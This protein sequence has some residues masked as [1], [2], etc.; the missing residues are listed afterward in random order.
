MFSIKAFYYSNCFSEIE[1]NETS[2][3]QN[4]AILIPGFS[5]KSLPDAWSTHGAIY[6]AFHQ[7]C[8]FADVQKTAADTKLKLVVLRSMAK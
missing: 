5:I 4:K 1:V 2:S 7:S 3:L 6:Y 8:V